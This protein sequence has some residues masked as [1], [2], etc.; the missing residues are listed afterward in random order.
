VN[1]QPNHSVIDIATGPGTVALMLSPLVKKVAALDFS[2]AMIGILKQQIEKRVID[3][4]AVQICDCQVL[5][6]ANDSFDLAFSQFGLMFFPD[7]M[8]GFRE[9]YRILKTNGFA[10][11]YSWAPVSDSPAMSLM[12]G[13]LLEG[14]PEA[15]PKDNETKTVVSGLDDLK[16]FR[17]EMENAGFRDITIEAITHEYPPY[18]PEEFWES[19]VKGSAP[20]TMM[21]SAFDEKTWEAKSKIS[22]EYLK[23]R[24]PGKRLTSTAYLAIGKK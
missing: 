3:N 20:I 2:P 8:A 19:M 4:I 24:M 7:R 16:V 17:L 23:Q 9:M 14:F 11:V 15:Q 10:S 1:P 18:T 21:K 13:A 22:I 12:M 5:P 6:F